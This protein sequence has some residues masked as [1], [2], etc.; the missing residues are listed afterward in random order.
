MGIRPRLAAMLIAL[1]AFLVRLLHVLSYESTPTND[2]AVYVEM[3]VR[4]LALANLFSMEGLCWFPPGYAIFMKPFFLLFE[5]PAALMAVRIAQAALGAWTCL[6]LYRIAA[7]T[8]SR[9]AGLAAAAAAAFYPH[10][11][12]YTS[13]WMSETLFIALYYAALL[14]LL[15][16]GPRPRA[17]SFYAAGLVAGA[18]LLVRP[19]AIS[20]APAALAAAWRVDGTRRANLGRLAIILAGALTLA[21]PWTLRNWIA[22]GHLVPIAPNGAFNLATGNHP[23]ATGRYTTPPSIP[24]NLWD[25]MDDY[26]SRALQFMV[27]DPWGA[28]LVI[29]RF[30]W[31]AFWELIPPWPLYSSN[32]LL[33]YGEHFFPWIPWRVVAALGLAGLGVVLAHRKKGWWIAPACLGTYL[34]F[35]LLYFGNAR[36]RM[37]IEG[38]FL[39]WA[40]ILAAALLRVPRRLRRVRTS[41]WA[42]FSGVA[43]FAI[44]AYGAWTAS[45]VR[46]AL[47][48]PGGIL[49]SAEQFPVL[50]TRKEIPLFGEEPLPLDR[51]RGRFLRLSLQ[52]WRMGPARDTPNNGLVRIEYRDRAGKRLSWLDHASYYLEAL[53]ADRW[54][55]VAFRSHIPP[56]AAA[57]LVILVPDPSSPDTLIIDQPILRYSPGNDLFLEALFPYL[58][59]E[60]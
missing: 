14:L 22:Y 12:F 9:L 8:F 18:A 34:A 11:V 54:T 55:T 24:G 2:M 32:P 44:L 41:E 31:L 58:R 13:A 21:A 36:Y 43:L 25:R 28:L 49:A 52:A 5:E 1:T 35:Y 48:E 40:G 27:E 57:A 30:K 16:A 50:T 19:V 20:L 3:A 15:R 37:P 38:L 47:R 4:R 26:Q 17:R 45:S 6:L 29:M 23:Q 10:F 7:H 46:S 39:V 53:P 51:R 56:A 33:Y 59:Y 60:E 42:A